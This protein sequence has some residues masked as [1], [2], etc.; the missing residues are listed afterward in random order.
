MVPVN[1]NISVIRFIVNGRI[2]PLKRQRSSEQW[3][4]DP[5]YMLSTRGKSKIPERLNNRVD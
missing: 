2:T 5:N 4:H 1:P 3:Q